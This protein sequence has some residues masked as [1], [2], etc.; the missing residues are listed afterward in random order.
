[1][2]GAAMMAVSQTTIE[3]VKSFEGFDIAGMNQLA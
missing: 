3:L 1:L 2:T